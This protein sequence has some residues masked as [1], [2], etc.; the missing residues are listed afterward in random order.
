MCSPSLGSHPPKPTEFSRVSPFDKALACCVSLIHR[1]MCSD[2]RLQMH[3]RH[4]MGV[5]M[6]LNITLNR[7]R[8]KTH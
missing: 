5:V 2:A 8:H 7:D 4:P 1:A 3:V 6:A